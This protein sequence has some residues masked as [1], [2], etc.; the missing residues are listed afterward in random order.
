MND[1]KEALIHMNGFQGL[2]DKPIKVSMAIPKPC[3]SEASKMAEQSNR[4]SEMYENYQ[5][6]RGAWGNY[7]VYQQSK[8]AP[9]IVSGSTKAPVIGGAVLD[10]DL[11]MMDNDDDDDSD[12][13]KDELKKEME[14]NRLIEHDVPVNVDAMNTE[15]IERSNEVWDAVERDRWIY[16][17][18]NDEGFAPSAKRGT[19][20]TRAQAFDPPNLDESQEQQL[21]L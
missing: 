19:K 18:D 4:Y 3:L 2:G 21:D 6:D 8:S 16:C 17:F 14:E 5:A 20:R 13:E 15:F 10:W 12:E 11:M 1:Q 9:V 7:G